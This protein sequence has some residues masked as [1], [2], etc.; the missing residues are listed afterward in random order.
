MSI[1]QRRRKRM[2]A[3]KAAAK[4]AEEKAQAPKLEAEK[5]VE[6]SESPEPKK[7]ARKKK[8]EDWIS[9]HGFL[10]SGKWSLHLLW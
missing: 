9:L 1:V 6:E 5:P 10:P 2:E 3:A 4:L 7:K 8:S